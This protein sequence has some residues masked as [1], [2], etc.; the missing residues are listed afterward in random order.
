MGGFT[1]L[2]HSIFCGFR[3]PRDECRHSCLSILDVDLD[4]NG[5][6]DYDLMKRQILGLNLTTYQGISRNF[7]GVSMK[8]DDR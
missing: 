4:L 7:D 5:K 1:F 8:F 3:T 6:F 2:I